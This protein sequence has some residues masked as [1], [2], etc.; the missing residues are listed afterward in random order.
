MYTPADIDRSDPDPND[1]PYAGWLYG[2]V[3]ITSQTKERLDRAALSLGVVGPLSG[4]GFTQRRW[5]E[6]FGWSQ[7]Q[8]WDHQLRNEP[9]LNLMVD[10]QWRYYD[11][12]TDWGFGADVTPH[13]G[14]ALGNVFTYAG[15]GATFRIG[16]D[17]ED[18]FGG[19][20]RISPALPGQ[21]AFTPRDSF[22][23]YEFRA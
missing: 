3:S 19:P 21:A 6:L 14:G 5:H 12:L 2:E 18:D 22:G 23:W 4:A 8:G 16:K 11:R 1:R 10:H 7:P 9:A 17:I 20:P 15:V 13:V